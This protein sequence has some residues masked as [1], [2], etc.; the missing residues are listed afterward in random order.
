MDLSVAAPRIRRIFS[1]GLDQTL[2]T[3]LHWMLWTA[4]SATQSPV[5]GIPRVG[6]WPVSGTDRANSPPLPYG[7]LAMPDWPDRIARLSSFM[8]GLNDLVDTCS[9]EAF[10]STALQAA[11]AALPFDSALWA[12]GAVTEA[13]PQVHAIELFNQPEQMMADWDHIKHLDTLHRTAMTRMGEVI[14][15]DADGPIG[16]PAFDPLIRAHVR[17]YGMRQMA[18]TARVDPLSNLFTAISL[19]RESPAQS[20]GPADVAVA[21]CV[22]EHLSAAWVRQRLR[23]VHVDSRSASGHAKALADAHGRIHVACAPFL[24]ALQS[25]WPGWVGPMLP[26]SLLKP[27]NARFTGSGIVVTSVRAGTMLHLHAR[28]RVSIDALSRRER[29]VATLIASGDDYRGVA[30]RL[31]IAPDTV[32]SHMKSIYRKT[33]AKNKAHLA[34]MLASPEQ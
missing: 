10:Q 18:S 14:T 12:V 17:R 26:A 29:E 2:G 5:C 22:F 7:W 3:A 8:L 23:S 9:D 24:A 16:G 20:F 33:G 27:A 31:H 21:A 6:E 25:E 34:Q 1:P 30:A 32:R 13:G 15:A 11:Q 19:Y 28:A 4:E